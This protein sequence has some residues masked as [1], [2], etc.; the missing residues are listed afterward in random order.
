MSASSQYAFS[1][2][3]YTGVL[4]GIGLGWL[5]YFLATFSLLTSATT[6]FITAYNLQDYIN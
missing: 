6:S 4:G 3:A 2:V 5:T 1:L